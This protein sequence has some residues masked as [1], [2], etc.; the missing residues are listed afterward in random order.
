V[1][2][3]P[4]GVRPTPEQPPDGRRQERP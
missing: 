3:N 2:S 4:I 1:R